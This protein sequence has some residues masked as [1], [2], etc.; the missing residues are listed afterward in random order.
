MATYI[1]G[2]LQGCLDELLCLL[3]EV[4]FDP[5]KDELWLTG[6]LVARGPKSLECL[7]YIKRLGASATTVL[8]NHD[9]HLL[10]VAKGKV[11]HKKRDHL[12]AL[13]NAHDSEALLHWLAQQP[14]LAIH[15]VHQFIMVHA[16]ISPQW[17]QKKAI[18]YAQEV[19]A[20][21]Q[22]E[23]LDWLLENMYGNTPSH[24]NKSLQGIDRYRMIINVFTRMRFCFPDGALEFA[25]KNSP[26]QNDDPNLHPWFEIKGPHLKGAPLI[27]GH[28][29]ALMGKVNKD[30][31]YALD[32]G[33]V[34]GNSMTLLRWEDKAVFSMP[35]PVY[36]T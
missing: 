32:T 16:G 36:S 19:E 15:P 33:C 18:H 10:A 12:D 14:L 30:N 28:W 35:C 22:S 34:W 8:G 27:F 20:L 23:R 26:K 5:Q 31:L 13:L 1:V 3:K 7:R 21:L 25:C 29:A 17:S 9:L 11:K 4:A 6:D 24:W 2:D